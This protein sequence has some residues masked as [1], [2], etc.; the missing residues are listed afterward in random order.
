MET[1][2]DTGTTC[3]VHKCHPLLY[4]L[5]QF[6]GRQKR[7][8]RSYLHCNSSLRDEQL[9]RSLRIILQKEIY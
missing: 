2:P 8:E 3:A 5:Y 6:V 9:I 7:V 1:L 4:S